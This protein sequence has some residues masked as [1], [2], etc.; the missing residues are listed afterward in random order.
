M[1]GSAVPRLMSL[2]AFYNVHAAGRLKDRDADL[3]RILARL[4]AAHPLHQF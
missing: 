1:T 4:E 3:R 2:I